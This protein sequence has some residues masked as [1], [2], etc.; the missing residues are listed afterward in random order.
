MVGTRRSALA[1]AGRGVGEEN[2][3]GAAGG[4]GGGRGAGRGAKRAAPQEPGRRQRP[5]AGA[6][7]RDAD[8]MG[9]DE[10]LELE[11]FEGEGAAGGAHGA[12]QQRPAAAVA[13]AAGFTFEELMT[14][15]RSVVADALGAAKDSKPE[16]RLAK[17]PAT[18]DVQAVLERVRKAPDYGGLAGRLEAR[19][20]RAGR[21]RGSW[22]REAC[23][24]DRGVGTTPRQYGTAGIYKGSGR[25]PCT[26]LVGHGNGILFPQYEQGNSIF[27]GGDLGWNWALACLGCK[28]KRLSG[29][30]T[31]EGKG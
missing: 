18:R 25:E 15:V 3:E 9:D 21:R 2:R 27:P 31:G 22:W 4:A 24:G 16:Y 17:D 10:L 1:G 29:L 20:S 7:R 12:R 26:K 11:R 14:G 8:S 5:F 19:E 28:G 30:G 23:L 13:A 6:T